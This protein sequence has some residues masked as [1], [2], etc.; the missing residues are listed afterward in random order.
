MEIKRRPPAYPRKG[1]SCL[2][3][4]LLGAALFVAG[5]AFANR[6]RV[7][8]AIV[9]DP[10]PAPTQSAADLAVRARIYERDRQ[11][12]QAVVSLRQAL[13]L[14]PTN[15]RLAIDLVDLLI[16]TGE[17]DEALVLVD[18]AIETDK[19]NDNLWVA[20]AA[21]HLAKGDRLKT[22]GQ[23]EGDHYLQAIEAGRSAITINFENS[24]AY[25][26]TAA[27][28]I[29]Q[30]P[31][32]WQEAQEMADNSIF[33]APSNPQTELEQEQL[34]T[35]LY[36]SGETL[37]NQ[38]WYESARENYE[39]AHD[40]DPSHIPTAISLSSVYY[41]YD[42]NRSG[43]IDLLRNALDYDP[44]NAEIYD[45][46]A[47]YYLNGG[48]FPQAEENAAL[49]V[50]YDPDMVRAHAHLG[51]AYFK[52]N[53]NYPKAIEEL[54]VA[55]DLYNTPTS[56]NALYFTLLGL[57][58]YFEDEANCPDAIPL[59]EQTLTV[60]AEL[61]PAKINAEDGLEFCRQAQLTQP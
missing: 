13:E 41:F 5:F 37:T 42:N 61:S 25:A 35:A 47:F 26:F 23:S 43:A 49:A 59:F 20:K 2:A 22:I 28:L 4:I 56:T 45:I 40:I 51:H 15:T 34:V 52:N 16:Q 21:S 58:Y 10:T 8:D 38:A 31:A 1:P 32:A 57:A 60:A 11:Y 7:V 39:Q 44:E 33:F 50:Q 19:A 46:L 24:D 27:G 14:D 36:Y 53:N 9:P 18:E 55:V 48:A 54:E 3:I 30:G 6:Q 29:T 17:H 12:K